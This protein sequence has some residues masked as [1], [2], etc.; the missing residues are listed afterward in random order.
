MDSTRLSYAY[1]GHDPE[2]WRNRA[3]RTAWSAQL[4]LVYLYGVTKGRY[5]AEFPVYVALDRPTDRRVDLV[6]GSPEGGGGVLVEIDGRSYGVRETRT[7][8]HQHG[9]RTRVLQAYTRRCTMCDLRH[10]PLLDAAHIVPDGMPNGA[11]VTANG[12]SLCKIHHA[13]YD[14]RFLGVRP[15]HAIEV[16][17][18]LLHEVDGP[19]LR[20]GLQ[21][22]QGQR[23][24][25]VPR[26]PVDRP[27]P[28]RLEWRYS[29]FLLG[30]G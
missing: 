23:L 10:E 18:E 15:D 11:A 30:R 1:E 7:R 22:L 28:E 4:P 13:A 6:F 3:L 27:D 20:H 24:R 8:L 19:M 9:F 14:Q 5:L 16:D 12:M 17:A 21:D 29:Q 2:F 25:T 26:R